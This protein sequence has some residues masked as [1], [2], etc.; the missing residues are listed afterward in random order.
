MKKTLAVLALSTLLATPA[1]ADS[2]PADSQP[3]DTDGGLTM[4]MKGISLNFGGFIEAAG[5]YRTRNLNSDLSTPFQKL[6]L[7]NSDGYY[8][9]ET[10]FSAR[11]SRL[12][13]LAKGDYNPTIHLG[14]YYEM[15]F[16]GGAPTANSNESNS[17]NPRIRQL[18][19]TA[20]WD[21]LGLHLLAGQ[22]WSLTT[23][24]NNGLMPQN[25]VSP[26]TI[27]AQYVPGFTWT[28][29]PQFRIVK[30]FGKQLWLAVSVENPQTVSASN[31]N[32]VALGQAGGGNFGSTSVSGTAT[33]GSPTFSNNTY[34]DFVVKASYDP[35]WGHF[36]VY[37]LIRVFKSSVVSN[38]VLNS[39][40]TSTNAV[41][42]GV[43]L[44]IIPKQMNVQVSG[45][46][47]KGIGR[48]GSGQ[49]ADA[50]VDANGYIVPLTEAQLLAGL[51]YDPTSEWNFY[52]YYGIEEIQRKDLGVYP[53]GNISDNT[54]VGNLALS[55]FGGQIQRVDQITV[56]TW[57]KFF[58]GRY[59]TMQAGLQYS[60]TEDKYFRGT[61]GAPLAT[62]NMV[63]SS[64][65]YYWQ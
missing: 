4:K 61:A 19:T 25:Y 10:R 23:L 26:R 49:L 35:S 20:D 56:G 14:G 24:Y 42:G 65:R 13:V 63:F 33:T 44:P 29:Q 30:D 11:Q 51:T 38:G 54:N 12:S 45:L 59:G 62:D 52:G 7:A 64:L 9:D 34:P 28:R 16:L 58:Q 22:A 18:Y 39:T 41:G 1:L 6:P 36:E 21:N 43:I 8:Q 3:A 31:T 15:D 5:I 46:Y 37:D 40:E 60:Y 57:W 32:D 48:Y 55:K 27:D 53:Y 17:Y 2:Q 50:T 47:G